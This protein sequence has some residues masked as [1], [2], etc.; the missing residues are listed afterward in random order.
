[1][2]ITP[3]PRAIFSTPRRGFTLVEIAIVLIVIGLVVGVITVGKEMMN[4]ARI[5]RLGSQVTQIQTAINQFQSQYDCAP[6]DCTNISSFGLGTNGNGNR[7]LD[8]G[9]A[10]EVIPQ[11]I[12]AKLLVGDAPASLWYQL[13]TPI[14]GIQASVGNAGQTSWNPGN[15]HLR[16]GKASG[17][18]MIGVGFI[19]YVLRDI[20]AKFDDGV[21]GGIIHAGS[22]GNVWNS[23]IATVNHCNP[24]AT[25][26]CCLVSQGHPWRYSTL[27]KTPAC[28]ADWDLNIGAL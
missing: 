21:N 25:T 11:L 6:G 28:T 24:D 3:M 19:P 22:A 12:A 14:P 27:T 8:N 13:Q 16:M 2:T 23:L 17:N 15:F 5:H 1:M 9:E 20:D 10:M 18:G 7:V 4:V 26:G